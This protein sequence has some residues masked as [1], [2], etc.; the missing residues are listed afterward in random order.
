MKFKKNFH[1]NGRMTK[2]YARKIRR[3]GGHGTKAPVTYQNDWRTQYKSGRVSKRRAGR[4]KRWRKKVLKVVDKDTSQR[5]YLF[6]TPYVSNSVLNQQAVVGFLLSG[7]NGAAGT[8]PN[9]DVNT[10]FLKEFTTL[11][12][13]VTSNLHF[14]SAIMELECNNTSDPGVDVIMDVYDVVMRRDVDNVV[15]SDLPNLMNQCFT[16]FQGTIGGTLPV[17]YS[18]VG[19][20]PFDCPAFCQYVKI[21]DK[22]RCLV[23]Q[24]QSVTLVNKD[25]RNKM[26]KGEWANSFTMGRG[27]RGYLIIWSTV[28]NGSGQIPV[29]QMSFWWTRNYHYCIKQNATNA[30]GQ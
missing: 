9:N 13:A 20:T 16:I 21:L 30:A 15:A 25:N 8:I 10:I 7:P 4:A 14:N 27:Q 26:V 6:N 22:K 5:T 24:G 28:V 19:A 11:A 18:T 29:G 17:A 3:R 2:R 23:Q 1:G 12:G